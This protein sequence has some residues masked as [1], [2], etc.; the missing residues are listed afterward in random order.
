MR[1]IPMHFAVLREAT[2]LDFELVF[3]EESD[4]HFA[5]GTPPTMDI[6][7]PID[8]KELVTRSNGVFGQSGTGKSVLTQTAPLRASSRATWRRCWS[9]TC[10]AS[11]PQ[12]LPG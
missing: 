6:K 5:L 1:N 2:E 3:G 12:Q 7:I 4:T 11:T 10:T 9:S 8:L